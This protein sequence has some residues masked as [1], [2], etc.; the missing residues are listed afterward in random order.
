MKVLSHNV[1][2][3]TVEPCI[4][5]IYDLIGDGAYKKSIHTNVVVEAGSLAQ[6]QLE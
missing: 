3:Q 5:T 1:C 4:R 2:I 6:I